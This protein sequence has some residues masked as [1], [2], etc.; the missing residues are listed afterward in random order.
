MRSKKLSENIAE[1]LLPLRDGD[2]LVEAKI[3]LVALLT[4]R[5]VSI[6]V[7]S[8]VRVPSIFSIVPCRALSLG[9]TP[10]NGRKSLTMVWSIRTLRSARNRVRFLRSAFHSRQMIWNSRT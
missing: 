4:C 9:M 2:G 8:P 7:V 6:A 5:S 1:W 3:V 10:P